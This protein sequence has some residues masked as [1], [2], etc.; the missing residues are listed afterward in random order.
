MR[1]IAA[2]VESADN[3]GTGGGSDKEPDTRAIDGG[4]DGRRKIVIAK[5]KR[6]Q[7]SV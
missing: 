6:A 5:Q 4:R 3:A 1:A 2:A 7:T